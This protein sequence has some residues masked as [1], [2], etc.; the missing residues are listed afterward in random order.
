MRYN[1]LTDVAHAYIS[2]NPCSRVGPKRYGTG[3]CDLTHGLVMHEYPTV[4]GLYIYIENNIRRD[5]M[6][7]FE[8]TCLTMCWVSVSVCLFGLIFSV[9]ECIRSRREEKEKPPKKSNKE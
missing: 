3:T 7:I 8:I 5:D 6:G 1:L 9:V 4:S 2:S